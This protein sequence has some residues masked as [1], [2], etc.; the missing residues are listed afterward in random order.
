MSMEGSQNTPTC[1]TFKPVIFSLVQEDFEF[2]T[3]PRPDNTAV[4]EEIIFL[5]MS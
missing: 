3:M 2:Y 1:F 5:V 4:A